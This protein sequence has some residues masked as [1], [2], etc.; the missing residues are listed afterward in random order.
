MGTPGTTV[1]ILFTTTAIDA[2][3]PLVSQTFLGVDVAL[4]LCEE[5]EALTAFGQC[6]AC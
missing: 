6:R 5:G 1:K 4:R 3:K 2:S